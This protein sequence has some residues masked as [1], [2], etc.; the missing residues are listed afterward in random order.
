MEHLRRPLPQVWV[1][2]PL[3][4]RGQREDQR[5]PA[6]AEGHAGGEPQGGGPLPRGGPLHSRGRHP[7]EPL[8]PA[9]QLLHEHHHV[10]V[11]GP[12]GAGR[13]GLRKQVLRF[14]GPLPPSP[15]FKASSNA[16]FSRETSLVLAAEN[17]LSLLLVPITTLSTL[18][19]VNAVIN[20]N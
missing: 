5:G 8:L 19:C 9:R 3:P 18:Y 12:P 20:V 1:P 17:S 14:E 15:A 13:A 6:G 2:S 11:N 7:A 10:Q 4:P 16:T